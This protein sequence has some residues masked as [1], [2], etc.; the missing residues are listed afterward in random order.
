MGK[1]SKTVEEIGKLN[2][3]GNVVPP[4]WFQFITFKNGKP[5]LSAIIILSEII[6]WYRPNEIKNEDTGLITWEDKFTPS[7]LQKSCQN[8][9]DYFGLSTDQAEDAMILLEELGLIK[10]EVRYNK[11]EKGKIK[12]K[13][14]FV[15]PVVKAVAAIT[16]PVS[17]SSKKKDSNRSG[18]DTVTVNETDNRSGIE[19]HR[20]GIDPVTAEHD[21]SGIDPAIHK[22]TLLHKNT[23]TENTIENP[24]EFSALPPEFLL[25]KPSAETNPELFTKAGNLKNKSQLLHDFAEAIAIALGYEMYP[26][27]PRAIR[28]AKAAIDAGLSLEDM[29]GCGLWM[30]R[31]DK[32]GFW[33]TKTIWMNNIVNHMQAYKKSG[34]VDNVL[35]AARPRDNFMNPGVYEKEYE[36]YAYIQY[37]PDK[38]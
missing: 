7:M 26:A 24:S 22:N 19:S 6:Y 14:P 10:R 28:E 16:F 30:Q 23:I 9:A 38:E 1:L 33:N 4:S 34:G 12:K 32:A 3:S 37:D 29:I 27:K 5:N 20:S 25:E 36:K 35:A 18:I 15:Q 2:L 31:N 11:D 13:V 17:R 8:F 21:R